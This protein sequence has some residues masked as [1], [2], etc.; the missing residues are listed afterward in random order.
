MQDETAGEVATARYS[1]HVWDDWVDGPVEEAVVVVWMVQVEREPGGV[2]G[3][4]VDGA[5]E[6]GGP[7][8]VGGVE[9]RVG[10]YYCGE[11]A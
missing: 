7:G 6:C 8:G 3:G 2:V 10:D 9:V 1:R 5:G 4:S 11:A